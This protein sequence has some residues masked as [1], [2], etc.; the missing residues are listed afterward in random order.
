MIQM[1]HFSI[2]KK[3]SNVIHESEQYPDMFSDDG[4]L[5]KQKTQVEPSDGLKNSH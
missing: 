4:I 5:I 2:Y 1:N 3:N